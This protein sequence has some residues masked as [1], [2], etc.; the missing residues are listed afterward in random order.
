MRAKAARLISNE[1]T[2]TQ[3]PNVDICVVACIVRYEIR[4]NVENFHNFGNR[5]ASLLVSRFIILLRIF[6]GWNSPNVRTQ[7][8]C[9]NKPKISVTVV[10]FELHAQSKDTLNTRFQMHVFVSYAVPFYAHTL[11]KLL[12]ECLNTFDNIYRFYFCRFIDTFEM[13]TGDGKIEFF[14]QE[15][16]KFFMKKA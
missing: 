11:K 7:T 16:N 13:K 3:T 8:P 10:T 12:S 5:Q 1:Y 15:W 4:E 9:S 2:H 6:C 14:S